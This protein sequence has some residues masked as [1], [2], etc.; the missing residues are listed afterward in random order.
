MNRAFRIIWSHVH[1]AFIV[2]DEMASARG[3]RGA[4]Q[5]LLAGAGLLAI[6]QPGMALAD[7]CVGGGLK[8]ISTDVGDDFCIMANGASVH[9]TESGSIYATE[10]VA[11]GGANGNFGY[12]LNEG[13][14]RAPSNRH[15]IWLGYDF[16]LSGDVTNS[17]TI[18]AGHGI[19][20]SEGS[21]G[22]NLINSGTINARNGIYLHDENSGW[23][24][25]LS[26][27]LRNSGTITA[28]N[29]GI[30]LKRANIAGDLLNEGQILGGAGYHGISL[31]NSTIGNIVNK[32]GGTIKGG[33]MGISIDDG[34]NVGSI[35]NS[36]TIEGDE[37]AIR[38]FLGGNLDNLYIDGNNTATIKGDVRAPN[39]ATVLKSGAVFGNT[40][41]FD[42]KSFTVEQGATL[43]LSAS[44]SA[45]E[46]GDG[47]WVWQGFHNLGT[48]AL[49]AGVTSTIHGD[50]NQAANGTLKIG[51]AD[52]D[53]FG[54]LVVN[55]TATLASNTKIDVNV[56]N[57]NY[58]FSVQS[59]Q[60]VLSATSLISDGTFSVTDNSLLFN[61]GAVKDGDTVDLTLTAAGP[62]EGTGLVEE[63]VN[64][65]GNSPAQGA[66][67]VLDQVITSD[68]TG[69][70]AGHFVGLTT[71]QQ[72]SDA[73]T[74]TL[75]TVAGNANNATSSTLASVNKVIQARQEGNSGLSSG[76]VVRADNN[77]WLKT[78][79][80]WAEQDGRSG[81]SGYDA[82]T[83]GLAIGADAAV[84]SNTRL[85]LSFAYART[86]LDNGSRIAPQDA[87][88][89]TFLLIGYG[90]YAL[91][92]S[93][94]L[95]FQLDVGQNRTKGK[96][97]MPFANATAK[98]DYDS[99]SVHAGLGIGHTLRF[100]EQLSFVPSVRLD[101]TWIDSE[102]YREKGAGA[103]NLHVDSNDSEELLFSVDGKLNYRLGDNTVLS[104]NLGAGYDLIDEKSSITSAYAGAP[105]ATFS[106]PGMDMEPW[107]ARAGLG[108]T[109]N[110]ANG[111]EVNLRYDA[112]ARSG[113]TN[114]GASLKLRWAF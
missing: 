27:D 48:V 21:I 60:D 109:H 57:P 85:G 36:G 46:M 56:A 40:N 47:I 77:L 96:R 22:G 102:A 16:A 49:A 98:A 5:L 20:G 50:Y 33:G 66:A 42:V 82:D 70:L 58:A 4:A 105:G 38:I 25:T 34:A 6:A 17:G 19:D 35:T 59:L 81:I 93:T 72:V 94:E 108:L 91:A 61:F 114:Q 2:A 52:D 30:F 37:F 79:G 43:N 78:F 7:P 69:E 71:E 113:F 1:Q 31:T 74:S 89:D 112:E 75:P 68:P 29:N 100:S 44:V 10:S 26:G 39:T 90:S 13:S 86:D 32:A 8:T 103:L 111:T 63:T 73:V 87:R 23:G 83:R 24:V 54:K 62:S 3:K 18:N 67:K 97:H 88:I 14:L 45:S 99:T 95:N 9:V 101:Y 51:V 106:T 55:G 12:I 104:A 107:L 92:E 64:N 80:S 84:S 110:L 28:T 65:L 11:V 76:D 15:G 53:T 41:A